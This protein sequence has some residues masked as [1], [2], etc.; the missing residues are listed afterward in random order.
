MRPI[1]LLLLVLVSHLNGAWAQAPTVAVVETME[2]LSEA[3]ANP[4]VNVVELRQHLRG[5]F[6][7]ELGGAAK[8]YVVVC[9]L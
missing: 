5:K 7:M 3:F 6:P 9:V 4:S 1:F 2:A 8:K